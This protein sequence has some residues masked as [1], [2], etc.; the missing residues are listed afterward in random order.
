MWGLGIATFA[1]IL[2]LL[3][4]LIIPTPTTTRSREEHE[5]YERQVGL[6]DE[7]VKQEDMERGDDGEEEDQA[8]EGKWWYIAPITS[9]FETT[10]PH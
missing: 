8:E 7:D 2:D 3:C 5:E 1:K 6:L 4:N 9:S 10:E